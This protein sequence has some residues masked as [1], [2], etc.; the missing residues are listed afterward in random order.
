MSTNGRSD[1]PD[2]SWLNQN[3]I[4]MNQTSLEDSFTHLSL[5]HMPL[6]SHGYALSPHPNRYN[7]A[8]KNRGHVSGYASVPLM[9]QTQFQ[10]FPSN[11]ELLCTVDSHRKFRGGVMNESSNNSN[12]LNIS[13]S[14]NG[15]HNQ[16]WLLQQH[17]NLNHHSIY[18]FRGRILLLAKE[19]GGSRVLQEIMK[20][21]KSQEEISFI[22]LELVYNVME[23]MMDPLGN[24]VFQKLVEICSEQQ[25]TRIILVVTNSDFRFVNMCLDIHGTRAVQ[26]LLEHVTTQEQQSLIMSALSTGVVALTKDTNGLHVVEHCLKHFSNEDNKYL[27]NIVANNCF[28]IATDKNGC[29]VMQHC[30]DYVQGE[31]KERLMAEIIVNASVLSEDCYGNYVVQHLVA[32]KI[33]RVTENLLRQLEGKFLLLSCNKYGSNVV[34][35]IFLDSAE[36]HSAHIIVELLHNPNVSRLL[37]DPFGNYVIKTALSV[38]KDAIRNALLE[39]IQLHS[40]MMRS[41]I[42]GKKLLDR[43]DNEKIRHM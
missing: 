9:S 22:F 16:R 4:Q 29:C 11:E 12:R 20:R 38:S 37:V 19:Q 1:F 14:V 23:L 42:Y 7:V 13:N 6:G 27:L 33:P 41:N 5:N 2:I 8:S 25:R 24:Y 40:A 34:E 30:I 28:E 21:L 39:L 3:S 17:Q 35:R 32:M 36:Q 15:R 43:V 26:K 18:D 31:T 10:R